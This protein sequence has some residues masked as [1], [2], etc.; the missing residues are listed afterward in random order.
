MSTA[1]RRRGLSLRRSANAFS[2]RDL[3]RRPSRRST[4]MRLCIVQPANIRVTRRRSDLVSLP[5][6]SPR[7]IEVLTTVAPYQLGFRRRPIVRRAK[8]PI[9]SGC[10]SHPTNWSLQVGSR[11]SGCGGNEAIEAFGKGHLGWPGEH[12]GRN[13]SERRA[14][15]ES[16]DA[17]ADR[18]IG[19]GRPPLLDEMSDSI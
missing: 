6:P 13:V 15:L 5:Q 19:S 16:D 10:N 9:F 4:V 11:R 7:R 3:R 2:T 12:A 17:E 14:S 8:A 1:P 18:I